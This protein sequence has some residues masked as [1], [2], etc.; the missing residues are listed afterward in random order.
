MVF[1]YR[2]STQEVRESSWIH[3]CTA[4]MI[5]KDLVAAITAATGGTICCSDG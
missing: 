2:E 3:V 1:N 5:N 4:A